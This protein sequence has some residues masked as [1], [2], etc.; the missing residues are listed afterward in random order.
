MRYI[1]N[2]QQ[3]FKLNNCLVPYSLINQLQPS[4]LFYKVI[5]IDRNACIRIHGHNKKTKR[6]SQRER[7]KTKNWQKAITADSCSSVTAD[8]D[9]ND[10]VVVVVVDDD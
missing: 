4:N 7:E 10:V 8:D 2:L 9:D 1:A 6:G 3:L 5:G